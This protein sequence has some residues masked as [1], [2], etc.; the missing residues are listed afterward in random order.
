MAGRKL[1]TK[2][3]EE[4]VW[5]E[6]VLMMLNNLNKKVEE[7]SVA[8]KNADSQLQPIV[9]TLQQIRQQGMIKN[10]GPLADSA[11]LLAVGAMRGSQMQRTRVLR[12]GLASFKQL[13]DRTMKATIDADVRDQGRKHDELEAAKVVDRAAKAAAAAANPEAPK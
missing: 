8:K 9:R 3:E 10:L 5:M 13:V 11:G 2:A 6:H 12:E 7:Y 1:G 4:V